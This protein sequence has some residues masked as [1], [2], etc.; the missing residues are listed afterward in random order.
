MKNNRYCILLILEQ[1][2]NAILIDFT[3]I[4]PLKATLVL[5]QVAKLLPLLD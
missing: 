2:N 5:I 4:K 3:L 1:L